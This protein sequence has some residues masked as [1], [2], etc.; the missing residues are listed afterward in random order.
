MKIVLIK[1]SST[2]RET[3]LIE[4]LKAVLLKMKDIVSVEVWSDL[5]E[6]NIRDY[7]KKERIDLLITF[8][9]VGFE[10]TT[11][12][13]G[14]AYNV[15]DCKQIHF[16]LEKNFPNEH[17]LSKQLSIAM[18][19]YCT[20]LKIYTKLL[21]RYPDIPFLRELKEWDA[22][23]DIQA[24]VEILCGAVKEVMKRCHMYSEKN[25]ATEN[26]D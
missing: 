25:K 12:T 22:K 18:F 9:L 19:F 5:V 6:K 1:G 3:E 8:D 15:L 11:L 10:Q 4:Q 14:I 7:I 24:K 2:T 20:D 26:G 21:E 16:L 17:L 23:R 13:G